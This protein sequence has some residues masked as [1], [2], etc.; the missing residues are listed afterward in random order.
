MIKGVAEFTGVLWKWKDRIQSPSSLLLPS[1]PS[2]AL[3][4][5]PSTASQQTRSRDRERYE[6]ERN[7]ERD[8]RSITTMRPRERERRV[9][10]APHTG[11]TSDFELRAKTSGGIPCD[12]SSTL[13][14]PA[15]HLLLRFIS[16]P[17]VHLRVFIEMFLGFDSFKQVLIHPDFSNSNSCKVLLGR[18]NLI[19]LNSFESKSGQMEEAGTN[20]RSP[21]DKWKCQGQ[22]DKSNHSKPTRV[23]GRGRDNFDSIFHVLLF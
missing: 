11:S 8:T 3:Q 15:D 17:V 6:T 12:S 4:N 7:R 23:V 9:G 5:H 14:S 1:N 18:S 2:T 13:A 16:F 21:M 10:R 19:H 22:M 20:G